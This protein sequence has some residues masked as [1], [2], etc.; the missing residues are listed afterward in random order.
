LH[1]RICAL[2]HIREKDLTDA[3]CFPEAYKQFALWCG[4]EFAYMTWSMS[5]MPMLI[6]N[7]LLHNTDCTKLPVCYD[8]Q[9]IFGREILRSSNRCSLDHAL[10]I[11]NMKGDQAHDAL[12]DARN[13]AKIC[14]FLDLDQ[15]LEEYA[16]PAYALP[17]CHKVYSSIHD[18]L[19]DEDQLLIPCPFCGAEIRCETWV[20]QDSHTYINYGFCPDE[21]DEFLLQLHVYKGTPG[22]YRI[23]R[24][25]YGMSDDLWEIYQDR[26]ALKG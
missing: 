21:E 2:T 11:L 26:L 15:Y 23:H 24:L 6:D 14:S 17:P 16:A 13:T 1:K 18:A 22:Q 12:H 20:P 4:E 7:M 9:R 19:H 5:D 25:F 3:P 10:E 8:I